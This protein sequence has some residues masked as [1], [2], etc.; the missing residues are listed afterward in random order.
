MI[1]A[2]LFE[3]VADSLARSPAA[4]R[5]D[6][7][8]AQRKRLAGRNE[9]TIRHCHN[10]APTAPAGFGRRG[11]RRH[12]MSF[13]VP[14]RL[15]VAAALASASPAFAL[16]DRAA[17]GPDAVPAMAE[18]G[19]P[20]VADA[21]LLDRYLWV[22]PATDAA[23]ANQSSLTRAQVVTLYNTLYVPGNS[24]A[25]GWT[26]S[27]SPSC[28]PGS[29]NATLRQAVLD[30]IN[31]FRQVAG[32]PNIAMFQPADAPGVNSQASALM[33]G[34]NA[35]VVGVNPHSPPNTWT[36]YSSAGA[37]AAGKSNLTKGAFGVSAING[38]MDDSGTNNTVV[39]HRRWLLYPPLAK[40]YSGDVSSATGV[41]AASNLW[42]IQNGS[43]GTWG[44]RAPTP[45]GMAWPPGGFVP[46]Q[47]LPSGSNRWS[48]SW[49]GA[50][51]ANATATVTRNGQ[52]IAILG[53]DSR[54]N[55]G[56]GDASVVFRPNNIAANGTAV[57]YA[58][59]GA[60][61]QDYVVT[62]TGM[63]GNGAPASITYTVTVIDPA[64]SAPPTISG[65]ISNGG[66][67]AGVQL[68]ARPATG[69]SCT[70]SDAGGNYSCTVPSGWSGVLFS[71]RVGGNR[72]P[73]QVF[74]SAVSSATSRNITAKTHASFACDLDIDNNGLLEADTDGVAILR[75]AAGMGQSSMTGLAGSCAATTSAS[76]LFA[77]ASA[78][79]NATGGS[80]QRAPTDAL[81]IA[82]AMR[83][84][85]GTGVTAGIGLGNEAGATRT[86]WGTGSDG[87]LRDW[88][89]NTCGADFQ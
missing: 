46:Y 19:P 34:S 65:T 87:Q 4:G 14:C 78:S 36:C 35:W 41:T 69:V 59:P 83:G 29:T 43:D 53:Y 20:P 85:T 33:Q 44:T 28:T 45:N 2:G 30:R 61:D 12:P 86:S 31:F 84:S 57:S 50:N 47:A 58:S 3:A 49:P 51:M 1:T 70:V 26:G 74:A 67:I 66:G 48:F 25:L 6:G 5:A 39:G 75:A 62:I 10:W 76:G 23:K 37:T 71:P 22:D 60:V 81:V 56:Y 21:D 8:A 38:Y 13:A 16:A 63:T 24:V 7:H 18:P 9:T 68:C 15:I 17:D 80:G 82:R 79:L 88:L 89:N 27:G 42:V 11:R 64:V 72:I 40:V 32:L 54:D 52:P 77:A 55:A 73:P